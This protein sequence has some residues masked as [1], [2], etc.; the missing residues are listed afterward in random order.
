MF[1]FAI[2]A[3]IRTCPKPA[4]FAVFDCFYEIFA[5]F[6]GGG[7]RVAVLAQDDLP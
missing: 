5:D 1:V 7:F 4:V 3:T 6:V 2:I